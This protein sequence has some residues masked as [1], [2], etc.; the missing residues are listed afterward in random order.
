MCAGSYKPTTPEGGVGHLTTMLLRVAWISDS[1]HET[2][3]YSPWWWSWLGWGQV[4]DSSSA[5]AFACPTFSWAQSGIFSI[6]WVVVSWSVC[7]HSTHVAEPCQPLLLDLFTDGWLL[8]TN[9]LVRMVLLA[10]E[11]QPWG[12]VMS[13]SSGITHVLKSSLN[14]VSVSD[15]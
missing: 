2:F 15:L 11:L 4:V 13:I 10:M 3:H 5:H 8:L 7:A 9:C 12:S 1:L 6:G 14:K